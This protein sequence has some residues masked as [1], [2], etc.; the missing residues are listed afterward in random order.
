MISFVAVS[1]SRWSSKCTTT[2][3]SPSNKV[4]PVKVLINMSGPI[5]RIRPDLL[6]V[7][8]PKFMDIL[9]SQSPKQRRERYSSVLQSFQAPGS[10]LGTRDHE[11]HRKRRAVLNPF[12]SQ[13]NVRRLSGVISQTMFNLL[14][15]MDGWAAA[16]RPV[17]MNLPF[18]AAT[19]DVIQSYAFGGGVACL[20][21]DDCNSAFFDI[22]LPSS[23]THLGPHM[24]YV[25]LLLINMPSWLMRLFIP[26]MGAFIEF[27]DVRC[28]PTRGTTKL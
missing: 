10:I 17:E 6:H 5:V 13:Q 25:S 26:R 18:R 28:S 2:T 7:N 21:I 16:G 12:F 4:P 9:Y 24:Y 15:R 11:L 3:V 20:D 23:V 19:K 14:R 22:M 27:L 8:D 1:I